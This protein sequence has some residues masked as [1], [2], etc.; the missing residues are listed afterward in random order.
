[1]THIA[2]LILMNVLLIMVMALARYGQTDKWTC[3]QTNIQMDIQTVIV[4]VKLR[5]RKEITN[6]AVMIL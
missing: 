2:V 3:R 4:S 5:K 6:K 1:M